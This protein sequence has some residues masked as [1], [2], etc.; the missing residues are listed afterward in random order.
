MTA[1]DGAEIDRV[2][3]ATDIVRPGADSYW[4][5]ERLPDSDRAMAFE[6]EA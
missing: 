1:R 3:T 6:R 5:A 4:R 2:A